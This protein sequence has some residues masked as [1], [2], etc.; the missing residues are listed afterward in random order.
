MP[1]IDEIRFDLSGVN[2]KN[3]S[4]SQV[5]VNDSGSTMTISSSNDYNNGNTYKSKNFPKTSIAN[6]NN[7]QIENILSKTTPIDIRVYGVTNNNDIDYPSINTRALIFRGLEFS[8]AAAP[9]QPNRQSVESISQNSFSV[10]HR[11]DQTESGVTGSSARIN[12]ITGKY[13]ELTGNDTLVSEIVTQNTNEQTKT[14]SLNLLNAGEDLT[15]IFDNLRFG[16]KYDYKVSVKN[17][18]SS[19]SSVDSAINTMSSFTELPTAGS[20]IL[21][22]DIHSDSLKNI[23]KPSSSSVLSNI[24]YIN[25]SESTGLKFANTAIQTFEVTDTTAT[26]SSADGVGKGVDDE[27][28]I[29][30]IEISK[31]EN[32]GSYSSLHL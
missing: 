16:T 25:I 28:D 23:L 13:T 7:S 21:T 19:T 27:N 18:F 31:N 32:G 24:I 30:Q 29:A 22:L 6:A 2:T 26:T 1:H 8:Q 14:T 3:T 17:N 10:N 11:V 12:E 20:S 15:I 4:Y 9:S 5:W